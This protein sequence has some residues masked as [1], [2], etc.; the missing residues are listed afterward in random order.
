MRRYLKKNK[1][2]IGVVG[3]SKIEKMAE[4]IGKSEEE[5]KKI[6]YNVA[7]IVAR[8]EYEIVLTPDKESSSEYL[9][10]NYLKL[11]GKRIVNIVPFDDKEHG[12][13]WVNTKLGETINCGTWE[14]Q[15]E[16][17]VKESDLLVCVGYAEGSII[18]ICYSKWFK[19]AVY[20]IKELV[21]GKLPKELEDD[22]DLRYISIEDLG[23]E[24]KK[25]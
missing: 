18:E 2:K 22:L 16:R 6:F 10:E 13:R 8:N 9:G 19:G 24:L 21:S 20:I 23:E 11:D 12:Y 25:N 17:L 1:M 14:N 7:E 5:I 4:S 3:P 15:P